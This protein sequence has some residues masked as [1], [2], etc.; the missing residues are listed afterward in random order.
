MKDSII[1]RVASY[2]RQSLIKGNPKAQVRIFN[3]VIGVLFLEKNEFIPYYDLAY[4]QQTG[5]Y[6]LSSFPDASNESLPFNTPNVPIIDLGRLVT[7]PEV[8][9]SIPLLMLNKIV[10]RHQYG[11]WGK[12]KKFQHI[13]LT[14]DILV[15]G[16]LATSDETQ[17][18][19]V[20]TLTGLGR[21]RSCYYIEG[22][23]YWI[24]T[25]AGL[26]TVLLAEEY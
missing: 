15:Q 16:S 12:L 11:D 13:Q 19:K 6:R 22:N 10:Q 8:Q 26:T 4:N 18:N 9:D 5:F 7:T 14:D 3:D 20:A 17:L 25:E 24:I 2:I 23:Q 21:I 1:I